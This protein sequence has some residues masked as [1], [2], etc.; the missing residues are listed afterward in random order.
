MATKL[1]PFRT[2]RP[3]AERELRNALASLDEIVETTL[4]DTKLVLSPEQAAELKYASDTLR[5][6]VEQL[7]RYFIDPASSA[8]TVDGVVRLRGGSG[9]RVGGLP[10]WLTGDPIGC[11]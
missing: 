5:P 11:W 2:G 10:H 1:P 4:C 6:A 7:L 9:D 8:R 3:S